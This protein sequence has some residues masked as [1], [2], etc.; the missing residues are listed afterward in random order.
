MTIV[1]WRRVASPP[2]LDRPP[3]PARLPWERLRAQPAAIRCVCFRDGCAK[4]VSP[5]PVLNEAFGSAK[6]RLALPSFHCGLITRRVFM[7]PFTA[8]TESSNFALLHEDQGYMKRK[9]RWGRDRTVRYGLNLKLKKKIPS[10]AAPRLT[11][12][13]PRKLWYSTFKRF[14]PKQRTTLAGNIII[15]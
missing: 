9:R 2:L 4:N 10:I 6:H 3:H 13:L 11:I 1:P 8:Q 14:V 7:A 5:A 12:L 15:V